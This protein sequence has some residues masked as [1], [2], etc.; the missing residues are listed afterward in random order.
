MKVLIT[1]IASFGLQAA[2]ALPQ[3]HNST[4]HNPILPGWH[5][6][7]SCIFVSE[8]NNTFFC[9][10]SSFSAFPGCPVYASADL[11]HW[12]LASSAL[13][14]PAQLPQIQTAT[15]SQTLGMFASTLRYHD[16]TFYLLTAW[17]YKPNN[18]TQF[19]LFTTK[20][21]YDDSSWTD[22]LHVENPK[23]RI[24]PDLFWD[25]DG[26]VVMAFSGAPIEAAYIDLTTGKAGEP[27]DMWNGTGFNN[28]EGPHLYKKDDYY[29]LLIAEGGTAL[30]HSTTIA[31]SR[32]LKGPWESSP[33]NPLVTARYTD[34][35]FQTVGHSDLFSDA[36]GNWWGVALATRGG[37]KLY[38]ETIHPMDRETVLYPVSWPKGGWPVADPVEGTMRGPLPVTPSGEKRSP[39]T[40]MGEKDVV[41]FQPGTSIP[42]QWLFW[43]APAKPESFTISPPSHPN[44]LRLTASKANITG[45]ASFKALDGLTLITRIQ[46]HTFFEFSVDVHPGFGK[47]AGDEVGVSVFVHQDHHI[48]LGILVEEDSADSSRN[49]VFR[50]RATD[51]SIALSQLP[52]PVVTP[53]PA[54][55][56]KSP[57]RLF[58]NGINT[59]HYELS[60]ASA[61]KSH[62]REH[63][64]LLPA[65][66]VGGQLLF[67]GALLGAYATTNGGNH[68]ME[69]YVSRWRYT[70]EAQEIGYG[71]YVWNR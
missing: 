51:S 36:N 60:A 71:D 6:D 44:T 56:S 62:E 22:A 61:S 20:N 34:R 35:Y 16:G 63:L 38:N 14:R 17:L 28:Q 30:E 31:R 64:A 32:S 42:K 12:D 58:I 59:T 55:W 70:P 57:I 25:D 18:G 65:S 2:T 48:D 53:V 23:G 8:W 41:D 69:G 33:H 66:L 5:S 40:F 26:S 19:V 46:T 47:I 50:C 9:T 54:A 11:T 15:T 52:S 1:L 13:N 27:F 3:P 21:P 7:P 29:Y 43:R 4:F 24:D 39:P 37:P 45:D 10:T 49:M 67:T 68:S